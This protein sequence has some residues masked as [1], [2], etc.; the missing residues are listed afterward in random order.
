M[1]AITTKCA[2]DRT[3]PECYRCGVE[4]RCAEFIPAQ[5]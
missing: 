5:P 4:F 2:A 3:E 1:C